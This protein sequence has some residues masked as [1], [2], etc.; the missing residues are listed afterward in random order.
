MFTQ[1]LVSKIQSLIEC[2]VAP[3]DPVKAKRP[4]YCAGTVKPLSSSPLLGLAVEFGPGTRPHYPKVL[5][6]YASFR[7]SSFVRFARAGMRGACTAPSCFAM[8]TVQDY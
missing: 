2:A 6:K 8:V 7:G 4:R 3:F 1:A 5:S